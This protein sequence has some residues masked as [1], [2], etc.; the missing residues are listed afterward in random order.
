[1]LQLSV[2]HSGF[3]FVRDPNEIIER[4]NLH[5]GG[6]VSQAV[7]MAFQVPINDMFTFSCL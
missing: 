6:K 5:S 3:R 2:E 7:E 4:L 1:M